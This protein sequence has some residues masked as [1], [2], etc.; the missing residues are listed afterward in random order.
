MIMKMKN[1]ISVLVAIIFVCS[2]GL[3]FSAPV[4]AAKQLQ[5]GSTSVDSSGDTREFDVPITLTGGFNDVNGLAF[6]LSYDSDVFE[7]LGLVQA[8]KEVYNGDDYNP[9]ENEPSSETIENALFYIA[10]AKPDEGLVRVA[11]AAAE[12]LAG[13]TADVVPFNARFRVFEGAAPGDYDIIA[14]KTIIG[15]DTAADAGYDEPTELDVAVGLD[16]AGDP[17][18]AV[19]YDVAL[20]PGT[21]TVTSTYTL[22]GKV[23]VN[24]EVLSGVQVMVMDGDIMVGIYPVNEDG[25]F[26]I[27]DLDSSKTY[28][29]IAMYGSASSSALTADQN[30]VY[31]WEGLAFG[32][33]TG[34]VSGLDNG[35]EVTL[36][37]ASDETLINKNVTI[38]GDGSDQVYVVD[39]LLPGEDYIVS[40]SGDGIQTLYYDGQTELAQ[41]TPVTVVAD[42]VTDGIDFTVT[43]LLLDMVHIYKPGLNL[44]PFTLPGTAI[45]RASDLDA[46]IVAANPSVNVSQIFGWDGQNQRFTNAYVNLGGGFAVG[47]F[48]LTLGSAYFIQVSDEATLQL[49][50]T[51][52]TELSLYNGLNV[53]GIPYGKRD[54][55]AMAADFDQ[56]IVTKTGLAV[57]QIFG[58]DADN[59]RFTNAYVN[60]GGGFAVGNFALLPGEAGY[61]VQVSGSGTYMP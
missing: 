52:Y 46:A 20:L 36:S 19:S 33:I 12:F 28:E 49:Q 4:E 13:D 11:A 54:A 34:T 8:D 17:A 50:G 57:E 37:A 40:I 14:Q 31:N 47:D 29:I 60:L 7:F 18:E 27:P 59:Q 56:E 44:V 48:D 39:N 23:T 53:I 1:H 24:G 15:P 45:S 41:A 35:Q 51:D 10:N 30:D 26:E 42:S 16:P 43:S 32:S 22:S 61:F 25:T 5:V 6:T 3:V 55:L 38:T 21:I 2:F 58:W 9:P